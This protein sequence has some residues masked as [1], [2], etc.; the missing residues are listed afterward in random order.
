M[1]RLR[2]MKG[3]AILL[4]ICML[5]GMVQTNAYAY[6]GSASMGTSGAVEEIYVGGP[7]AI[8]GND[9]SFDMPYATLKDA[10]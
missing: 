9:G 2:R 6:D 7:N 3:L 10:A 8:S 1:L 5:M 4:S